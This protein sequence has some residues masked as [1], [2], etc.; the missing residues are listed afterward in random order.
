MAGY[1]QVGL[2]GALVVEP[3]FGEHLRLEDVDVGVLLVQSTHQL[4]DVLPE[5][6]RPTNVGQS[7]TSGL[8]R[9]SHVAA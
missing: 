8:R 1:Y 9:H 7:H 3:L 4:A 6:A 5:P 2:P